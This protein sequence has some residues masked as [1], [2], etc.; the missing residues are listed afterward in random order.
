MESTF[1]TTQELSKYLKL[2]EKTILKMAQSG[3]IPGVKIANQWRFHLQVVDEYLQDRIVKSSSYNNFDKIVASAD[4]M[5][6]SRLI[7]TVT[8]N[9]TLNSDN[10]N[11]LI[12]ELSQIAHDSNVAVSLKTVYEQLLKRENMLSTAIGKGIAVPHPRNPS[13]ELFNKPAVI[14]GRSVKGI[15]FSSPDKQKVHLFFMPC[16]PDVVLHLKLL[17]KISHLLEARDIFNKCMR[18]QSKEQLFKLLLEIERRN[19][20]AKKTGDKKNG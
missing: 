13:D 20:F 15:E 4:I 14:F 19:I 16:A 3:E 9:L 8:V 18:L 2:N 12:Y 17:S 1:L 6:L 10:K 7:D 11:D 5:P